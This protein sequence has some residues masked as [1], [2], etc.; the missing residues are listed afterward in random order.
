MVY[1][2]STPESLAAI[3]AEAAAADPTLAF[4]EVGV[5]QGSSLVVIADAT[6][7]QCFGVDAF[8]DA[9][10]SSGTEPGTRFSRDDYDI[11][12]E[13]INEHG[14]ADRVKLI[15]GQSVDVAKHWMEG[16]IG[17]FYLDAEHS[18]D[19][20]LDDFDAWCP[21]FAPGCRILFDDYRSRFPGVMAAVDHLV[22]VKRIE[23]IRVVDNRLA[24]SRLARVRGL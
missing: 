1:S 11:A 14:L 9:Q 20:V 2:L 10:Y 4:V 19:A 24:V 23:P 12:R 17:F 16:P 6:V 22:Y 7:G 21:H 18:Y 8:G 13:N 3:S 5:Y 15:Q